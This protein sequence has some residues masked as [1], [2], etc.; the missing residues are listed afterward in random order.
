[1]TLKSVRLHDVCKTTSGG[2]PSREI[3][4]YYEDGTIPWV[5][6]GELRDG[7]IFEVEEYIT[8]AAIDHSSAKIFPSG[9]LLVALYGA[10]AGKLGILKIDAATN[11]AVC[12]IFVDNQIDRDYLYFFLLLQRNSLI[13]SRTGGAQPNISQDTIRNLLIPLPPLAEQQR[14]AGLLRRAD[15]LRRLRRY[16]L[17]VSAGY[18]QAVFVEM[19]GDYILKSQ[20]STRMGEL[21]TIT[22]GGT[23]SREIG[24]YF[25]G[26]I[27]CT[28]FA[29]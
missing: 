24:R 14:I 17:D 8:Q 16:A 19:F 11:Q 25:E 15:R 1:M 18:L 29:L 23:P 26:D 28:I 10:T 21:V 12:A 9:T 27:P 20:A 2:T 5:K 13:E 6:S 3:R 4:E 7:P 22:G